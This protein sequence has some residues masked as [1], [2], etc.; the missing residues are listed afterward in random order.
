M[1]SGGLFTR[2]LLLLLYLAVLMGGVLY[3]LSQAPNPVEVSD[4]LA[5]KYTALAAVDGYGSDH[6]IADL[7]EHY[8][9]A[10]TDWRTLHP[11]P[12]AALLFQVTLVPIPDDKI[13]K[14]MAVVSVVSAIVIAWATSRLARAPVLGPIL[15]VGLISFV[16]LQQGNLWKTTV[17]AMVAVAWVLAMRAPNAAGL[18]L[19]IAAATK[20][21]PLF[22]LAAMWRLNRK[23]VLV[24]VATGVALTVAGLMLPGVSLGGSIETL[25]AA[26]GFV[27]TYGNLTFAAGLAYLGVPFAEYVGAGVGFASLLWLM[28]KVEDPDLFVGWSIVLGLASS[29]IAWVT[30]WIAAVP[31]LGYL[32]LSF[33]PPR[34]LVEA[35]PELT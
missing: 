13:L 7:V 1:S 10:E 29:T 8:T 35:P 21:W 17:G 23:V 11:R 12:P 34:G 14:V 24:G 31:V 20:I 28:A 25:R 4:A 16:D 5:D 19:G 30:Y 22:V 26:S 9:G 15:A 3:G 33:G 6:S 32:S 2:G 18:L 27:A